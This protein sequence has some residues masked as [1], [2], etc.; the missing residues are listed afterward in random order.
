MTTRILAASSIA[1]TLLL[2]TASIASAET[3]SVSCSGV[4]GTGSIAW[5]AS[6]NGGVEPVSFLWGNGSTSTNQT[7]SYSP[8][9]QTIS[10][11]GTD[12]SS[13]VATSN[14]SATVPTPL[15]QPSIGSFVA[16]PSNISLGGTSVL[17]WTVTNASSTSL[18]QGIGVVSST[19]I[20]VS[21]SFTK[22]YT[23]SAINP[24]NTVTS[25]VTVTV[26]T[27]TSGTGSGG[28]V[29]EKIKS[30]L[31]QI[32]LLQSQLA[33]LIASRYGGTVDNPP[34][35]PPGQIS[36]I[37]C[38][39][40][41][42]NLRHGDHG[43]DVRKLQVMLQSDPSTGFTAEPTGFFG[44]ITKKAMMKFQ[45]KHGIVSS[46]IETDGSAGPLTRGFFNRSCGKGLIKH[47]GNWLNASSSKLHD[48]DDDDSATSSSSRGK[49]DENK[50][51]G[52]GKN[53]SSTDE[54]S[55]ESDDDGDDD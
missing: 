17:S 15:L 34:F 11:Q 18:N 50:G 13:T 28:G 4:P 24:N 51:K 27:S 55:S 43:D 36:K 22:T 40:L 12:A 2:A 29:Q 33:Q 53:A 23:L 38:I 35:I 42:R 14:C 41:G 6:S 32:A 5:T 30:L 54:D 9:L 25:S 49:S 45:I 3:L 52:K 31:Q 21:P 48:D 19:S 16:T 39:E 7:V 10:I 47:G 44:P 8:G 46:E 1:A 37:A 20:T 26:G